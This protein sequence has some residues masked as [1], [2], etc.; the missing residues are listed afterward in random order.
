MAPQDEL[1]DGDQDSGQDECRRQAIALLESL[2]TD[3][4]TAQLQRLTD[5]ELANE[6]L[7]RCSSGA[8]ATIADC[9]LELLWSHLLELTQALCIQ[10]HLLLDLEALARSAALRVDV[11]IRMGL[12]GLSATSLLRQALEQT[13]AWARFQPEY[14]SVPLH[15][16]P[17][18]GAGLVDHE[19]AMLLNG[20]DASSRRIVF[21]AWVR[22]LPPERIEES[23]GL[24]LERIECIL[25]GVLRATLRITRRAKDRGDDRAADA[26]PEEHRFWS[27]Q[28]DPEHRHDEP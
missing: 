2:G 6:L 19:I 11:Q 28:E 1:H 12:R 20:L 24:C 25:E 27:S 17:S 16:A 10:E 21:M 4:T 13:A 23:T 26:H 9:V 7:A 3:S 8:A 14:C 15:P 22:R 5:V 18:K